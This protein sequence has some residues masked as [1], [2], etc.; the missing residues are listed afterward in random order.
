LEI[1]LIYLKSFECDEV[2]SSERG[3]VDWRREADLGDR[4]SISPENARFRAT[5]SED[6]VGRGVEDAL[7]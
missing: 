4:R 7:A 1:T 2:R 3:P 6:A 5:N